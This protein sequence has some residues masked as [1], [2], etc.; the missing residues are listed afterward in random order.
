[1]SVHR[2]YTE[3]I[4]STPLSTQISWLP[5]ASSRLKQCGGGVLL[6]TKLVCFLLSTPSVFFI[7]YSI[8]LVKLYITKLRKGM[9]KKNVGQKVI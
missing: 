1:M 9:E 4:V 7:L 5:A 2:A 3:L 8:L 6:T